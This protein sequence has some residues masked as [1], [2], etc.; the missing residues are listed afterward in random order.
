MPNENVYTE[1]HGFKFPNGTTIP[2]EDAEAREDISEIKQSLSD[3]ENV[4]E[5]IDGVT[6]YKQILNQDIISFNV[7][8]SM[9]IIKLVSNISNVNGCTEANVTVSGKNLWGG[10]KFADDIV[11]KVPNATKNTTNHTVTYSANNISE[12]ILFNNFKENT[13]YS[14]FIDLVSGT[15]TNL[16]VVY[17]DGTSQGIAGNIYPFITEANKSVDYII[18]I[19]AG[20]STTINYLTSGLFKGEITA[21]DFE[22]YNG[23]T[24]NIPFVDSGGG[25]LT[26]Y[27]GSVDLISGIL[28]DDDNTTTYQLSANPIN[29]LQGDNNIWSD[30]GSIANVGYLDI[31]NIS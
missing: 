30:T 18:G 9:P 28:I 26:I 25:T 8:S 22:A 21:Q 14:I 17:K 13:Q 11:A 15:R 31:L 2:I 29:D 7:E 16:R 1:A 10:E 24:Y 27:N 6:I 3:L 12:K 23:H 20:G 4:I 19:W 5:Q